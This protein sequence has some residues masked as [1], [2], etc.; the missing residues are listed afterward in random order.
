MAAE[1]AGGLAVGHDC[2]VCGSADHPHPAIARAGAPDAAAERAARSA[3][4]D[5]EATRHAHDVRVRDLVS[6]IAAL[7]ETADGDVDELAAGAADAE[8]DLPALRRLGPG[9]APAPRGAPSGRGAARAP[10]LTTGRAGR[11]DR[12]ERQRHDHTGRR[13]RGNPAGAR[14]AARGH[15]L[16]HPRRGRAPPRAGCRGVRAGAAGRPRGNRRAEAPRG[17]DGRA[18]PRPRTQP[19][20][21]TCPPPS[22]PSLEEQELHRLE[23]MVREH[24]AAVARTDARLADPDLLAASR[25]PAARPATSADRA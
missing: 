25:A 8:T 15:G 14:R 5:A 13:G 17:A 3:V 24:D 9:R 1:L 4:D 21:T 6:Q 7:T 19:A 20:S 12:G 2:P 11:R 18:P 22:T 16:H 10:R 23:A